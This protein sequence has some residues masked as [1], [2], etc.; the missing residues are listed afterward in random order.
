MLKWSWRKFLSR[1]GTRVGRCG[2][3]VSLGGWG[4]SPSA[5]SILGMQ[6][7]QSYFFN[8]GVVGA[9]VGV[10]FSNKYESGVRIAFLS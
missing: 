10:D 5:I 1:A 4:W 3:G 8:Y 6:S 9:G 7:V 2:S